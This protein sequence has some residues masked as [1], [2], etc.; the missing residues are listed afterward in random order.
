MPSG[1]ICS[2]L[3]FLLTPPLQR[4]TAIVQTR[5][6]VLQ[7]RLNLAAIQAQMP[8]AAPVDLSRQERTPSLSHSAP[9][10]DSSPRMSHPA[11]GGYWQ[12]YP[13]ASASSERIHLPPPMGY[14]RD[15]RM[16]PHAHPH[17]P[18]DRSDSASSR[19]PEGLEMLLEG[20]REAERK[21]RL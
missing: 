3:S 20:V 1:D 13:P 4:L 12:Q 16:H 17:S 14:E 18:R 11:A 6:T 19:R 9:S 8:S 10:T 15:H 5:L 7:A 21:D 2:L